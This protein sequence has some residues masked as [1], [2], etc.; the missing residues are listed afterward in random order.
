MARGK[1]E[2]DALAVLDPEIEAIVNSGRFPLP[3]I[4]LSNGYE[5]PL[6][7]FRELEARWPTP[8]SIPEVSESNLKYKTR[9]GAELNL[10]LFHAANAKAGPKPLVIFF[11][12]G[13]GV[14]GNAYSVAPLARDLVRDHDCIVISPHYRL[15]PESPFPTGPNDAWDAFEYIGTNAA[16]IHPEIDLYRGLIVG[17][18]SQGAVLTSLIALRAKDTPSLPKITGLYFAAGGF[19]ASPESIPAKYRDLY[20]SRTDERCLRAPMLN[21]ETKAMFDAAYNP[22]TASPLYRAFNNVPLDLHKDLAPKVYFQVCGADILRDDA[23]IYAQLLEDLGVNVKVDV[24]EGAPHV[25]WSV[26]VSTKLAGR[27]KQ[28]TRGAVA[29]LLGHGAGEKL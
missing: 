2:L 5:A 26:F 29:W 8:P 23:L 6:A 12:G 3:Q 7:M 13:G 24:Y 25:F 18:A 22:D 10:F 17:G 1:E 15:A 21:K 9:D 16:S 27:W 14:M 20:L 4:D 28:D 19:I 11:H